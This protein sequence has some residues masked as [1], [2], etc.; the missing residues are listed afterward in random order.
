MTQWTSRVKTLTTAFAL[1]ATVFMA[2][3]ISNTNAQENASSCQN[4]P[5]DENSFVNRKITP[6][7]FQEITSCH[8]TWLHD[9]DAGKQM[10]VIGADMNNVVMR[11][12]M[13]GVLFREV[14]L[15]SANLWKLKLTDA[16]LQKNSFYGA[17]MPEVNLSGSDLTDANF[18]NAQMDSANLDDTNLTNADF[19]LAKLNAASFKGA[20]MDGVKLTYQPEHMNG[21]DL[22]NAR[23]TD[24]VEFYDVAGNLFTDIHIN[25]ATGQIDVNSLEKK[26][27][28]KPLQCEDGKCPGISDG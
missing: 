11:G 22:T 10:R 17:Y 7:E 8:K 2:G 20:N 6:Q 3:P 27:L 18:Q 28:I 23:N 26:Q 25:S 24:S 5:Y 14:D 13:S 19:R 12:D 16:D 1:A 15:D 9:K 21:I 4:L